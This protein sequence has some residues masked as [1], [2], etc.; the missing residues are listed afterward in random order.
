[1]FFRACKRELYKTIMH[2]PTWALIVCSVL[3]AVI[4]NSTG[5]IYS[6]TKLERL[7]GNQ[8]VSVAATALGLEGEVTA[9]NLIEAVM[10]KQFYAV[11]RHTS[12]G[13]AWISIVFAAYFVCNDYHERGIETLFTHGA[14]KRTVFWSKWI[15]CMVTFWLTA[16]IILMIMMF[17]YTVLS[18]QSAGL[19]TR[20]FLL[21]S[22]MILAF[23][24]Q[25]ALI[26][27]VCRNMLWTAGVTFAVMML[28]NI[29]PIMDPIRI[30][31]YENLWKSDAPL[32][33]TQMALTNSIT[34]LVVCT[35]VA[36]I[37]FQKMELKREV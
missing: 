28:Q 23:G 34:L 19:V 8:P 32:A 37:C 33:L 10:E 27:F 17:R 24:S 21:Y 35:V 2:R 1:M 25:C 29:S 4:I 9:D 13:L 7:Y 12:S 18:R 11:F 36:R 6:A 14:S 22:L 15:S 3:V 31:Q 5:G 26:A 20:D 30:M 16:M